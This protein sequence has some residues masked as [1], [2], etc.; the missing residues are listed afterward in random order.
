MLGPNTEACKHKPAKPTIWRRADWLCHAVPLC[1][2]TLAL[3]QQLC[4]DA[5]VPPVTAV[6]AK[7]DQLGLANGHHLEVAHTAN[8]ARHVSCQQCSPDVLREAFTL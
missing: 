6:Q 4:T 2:L 3:A 1:L 7:V 8:I 5:S